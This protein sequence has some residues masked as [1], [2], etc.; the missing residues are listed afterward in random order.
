MLI[1]P[2]LSEGQFRTA[3]LIAS[4]FGFIA[5]LVT[6]F[7]GFIQYRRGEKWKRGEFIANAIK[8]FESN[9]TVRYALLMIDYGRRKINIFQ[10]PNLSDVEG[11]RI[12]RGIQWRAL[13]PHTLKEDFEEYRDESLKVSSPSSQAASQPADTE[14]VEDIFTPL[15]AKIRDTYDVFLDYLER[16]A[17]LIELRLVTAEEFDP[18]LSYWIDAI[19]KNEHPEI[20]AIWQCTLLTYINFY[21]YPGVRCLFAAYGKDISPDGKLYQHLMEELKK[22]PPGKVDRTELAKRLYSSIKEIPPLRCQKEM[23]HKFPGV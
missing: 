15:E 19:T 18:Y 6:L 8:E 1:L 17:S 16:F 14:D 3:Q 4:I 22:L 23:S 21:G 9:P 10:T 12:T 5:V 20:D 2:E 7:F 13:L 11:V